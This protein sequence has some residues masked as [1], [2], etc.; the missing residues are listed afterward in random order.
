MSCL[1][2]REIEA[3]ERTIARNK[4]A[5]KRLSSLTE[6]TLDSYSAGP[7]G[8]LEMLKRTDLMRPDNFERRFK[9]FAGV[10]AH[11]NALLS[12]IGANANSFYADL[13]RV[14]C[15]YY[16]ARGEAAPATMAS[17]DLTPGRCCTKHTLPVARVR[18]TTTQNRC[19]KGFPAQTFE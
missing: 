18:S 2:E 12:G 1:L 13:C 8:A 9:R 17:P 10:V 5:L 15:E 11:N 14:R 19:L 4:D 3:C 7:D 16:K 6:E